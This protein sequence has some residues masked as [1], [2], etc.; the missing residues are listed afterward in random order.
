MCNWIE[1]E[2]LDGSGDVVTTAGEL[3][4]IIGCEPCELISESGRGLSFDECLCDL[5]EK[6][7]GEKFGY[8]VEIRPNGGF[9]VLMRQE[10]A[11]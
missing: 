5:D 11:V 7:T 4:A 9:D 3:A 1:V 6:S 10:S 8:H 2:K